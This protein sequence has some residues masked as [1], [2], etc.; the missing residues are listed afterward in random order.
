VLNAMLVDDEPMALKRLKGVL[1]KTGLVKVKQTYTAPVKALG[2]FR[3][4]DPEI[5]FLD[6]EM[7]G[8]SGLELARELQRIKPGVE[9]VVVSAHGHYALEAFEAHVSGFL[10][11]PIDPKKA[12]DLVHALLNK[13]QKT[14]KTMGEITQEKHLYVSSFGGFAIYTNREKPRYLQWRTNKTRELFAFL[15]YHQGQPVTRD[16]V[17]DALWPEMNLEK[18]ERNFY[19]TCCYLRK[20]LKEAGLSEAVQRDNGSYRLQLELFDSDENQLIHHLDQERCDA[21]SLEELETMIHLYQG[22]YCGSEDYSWAEGKRAY[23]EHQV[24]RVLW[25]MHDSYQKMKDHGKVFEVL[26][27]ML[28][29]DPYQDAAQKKILEHLKTNGNAE[30]VFRYYSQFHQFY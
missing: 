3:K 27:K 5:V 12:C 2:N 14:I 18:A 9:V 11:K 15:H 6:I 19:T 28:R 24:M 7:P 1:Q 17:L 25:K 23:Y 20:M 16:T 8:M 10:L 30:S 22:E 4:D 29:I 26:H 13:K 21:L